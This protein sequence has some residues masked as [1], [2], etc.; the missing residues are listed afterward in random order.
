MDHFTLVVVCLDVV[1][2]VVV[3]VVFCFGE[4]AGKLSNLWKRIFCFSR[5]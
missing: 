2:V 1:V 3:V 4:E 5:S